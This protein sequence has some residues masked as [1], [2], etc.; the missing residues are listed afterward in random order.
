MRSRSRRSGFVLITMAASALVM[1]GALG[2]AFDIGRMYIAKSELQSFA[3]AAALAATLRLN[4]ESTGITRAQ[5]E[6]ANMRTLHK[7]NLASTQLSANDVTVDFAQSVNN[8][9]PVNWS[10][11]PGNATGYSFTRV[12]VRASMPIY[13]MAAVRGATQSSIATTATAGQLELGPNSVPLG[14]F[15]FTPIAH[16]DVKPNF[17]FVAGKQY[18]LKWASSPKING[19]NVCQGDKKQAVLDAAERRGSENRGFYGSGAASVLKDQVANDTPVAFY[20]EGSNIVLTGG[21]T[22]TVK[23]ALQQRVN[24][25][26]DPS[27]TSFSSYKEHGRSRRITTVPVTDSVNGVRI[28]G[29]A[30]FFLL[31]A[32]NYSNAQGNEPWCAVYIGPGTPEGA[33]STGANTSAMI[34][35]VRLWQ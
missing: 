23:D 5:A 28:V 8:G 22:S 32:S 19:N 1:T 12:T 35:R 14:M 6:V 26:A 31:P 17:G 13:F 30:R 20:P 21:A 11:N 27:S 3:D 4:G 33:D 25:D 7:W 2:M 29:F 15:P 18:T 24:Q 16:E 10:S 9:P 34:T